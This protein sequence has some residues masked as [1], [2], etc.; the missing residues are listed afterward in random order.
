M[1]GSFAV[2]DVLGIK[3]TFDITN[4]VFFPGNL[5]FLEFYG[6]PIDF[7]RLA[8]PGYIKIIF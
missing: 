2:F 1:A 7:T 8:I 4:S 6:N 5:Q 3:N